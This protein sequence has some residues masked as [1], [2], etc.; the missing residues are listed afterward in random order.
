VSFYLLQLAQNAFWAA[1]A[2]L[3]FAVLF[4]VPVRTLWG[5][6]FCGALG[7]TLRRILVDQQLVTIELGT[8]VGAAA[9]GFAALLLARRFA[10]PQAIFSVSG[11][12]PMVPGSFGFR[13]M[14]GFVLV[15]SSGE[16]AGAE[17]L[18]E[19]SVNLIRTV[20]IVGALAIGIALPS[21]LFRRRRPVV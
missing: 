12:I 6:A 5:C 21:L 15:V 16:A 10:A 11:V 3:G 1:L 17:L 9:V 7:H 14:M 4:N 18:V 8:L 2:A 19:A 20:L 13:A